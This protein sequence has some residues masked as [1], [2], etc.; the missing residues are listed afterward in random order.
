MTLL[1]GLTHQLPD[2]AIQSV[3]R[4]PG[5]SLRFRNL[6][7]MSSPE[8]ITGIQLRLHLPLGILAAAG[9]EAPGREPAPPELR[10]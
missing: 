1:S 6:L 5:S 9:V 8:F 10:L 4:L 7:S 3:L 2:G